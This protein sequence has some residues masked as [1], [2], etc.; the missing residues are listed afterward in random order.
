[1]SAG[2]VRKD[3]PKPYHN[4]DLRMQNEEGG[5]AERGGERPVYRD[6]GLAGLDQDFESMT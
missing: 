2:W 1:M 3:F 4:V 5:S 6:A